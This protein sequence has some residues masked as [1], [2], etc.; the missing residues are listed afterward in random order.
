MRHDHNAHEF[1]LDHAA[2]IAPVGLLAPA[3]F[4][5]FLTVAVENPP[6]RSAFDRY[7]PGQAHA[8]PQFFLIAKHEAAVLAA[9]CTIPQHSDAARQF[10]EGV[11]ADLATNLALR[12][13]A[14]YLFSTA[15]SSV[16]TDGTRLGNKPHVLDRCRQPPAIRTGQIAERQPHARMHFVV[17]L[18]VVWRR[19]VIASDFHAGRRIKFAK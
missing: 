4:L 16:P 6:S 5:V 11:I 7:R 10:L 2:V 12:S 18:G 15:N 19:R 1:V 13:A 9:K 3:L 14:M 8:E 17:V